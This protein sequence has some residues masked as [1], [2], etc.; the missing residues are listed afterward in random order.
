MPTR[1]L[2]ASALV[3]SLSSAL[4]FVASCRGPSAGSPIATRGDD[5]AMQQ[6]PSTAAR[7]ATPAAKPGAEVER[8]IAWPSADANEQAAA[9]VAPPTLTPPPVPPPMPPP[10]VTIEL[11]PAEEG[12]GSLASADCV[13]PIEPEADDAREASDVVPDE[14]R[15]RHPDS[16][17]VRVA[18][19]PPEG[20]ERQPG[21]SAVY[22][23]AS[24]GGFDR[25]PRGAQDP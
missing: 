4:I 12:Q 2:R 9:D 25:D 13:C 15:Y 24:P 7:P 21:T 11:E 17:A 10:F 18:G 20:F 14:R 3:L 6:K 16:S 5:G 23:R 1:A 8:P 19:G 22:G